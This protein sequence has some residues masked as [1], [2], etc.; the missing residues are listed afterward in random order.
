M[1]QSPAPTVMR[2]PIFHRDKLTRLVSQSVS[3]LVWFKGRRVVV[4]V[5]EERRRV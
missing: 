5:K 4:E 1:D 3:E 2:R